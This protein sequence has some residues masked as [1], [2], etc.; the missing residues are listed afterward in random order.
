[1]V[2]CRKGRCFGDGVLSFRDGLE[3]EIP[4]GLLGWWESRSDTRKMSNASL[5]KGFL[6]CYRL[7]IN[8][9]YQS[10]QNITIDYQLGLIQKV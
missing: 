10:S 5:M 9:N 7:Q 8:F 2:T 1:M 4:V 6:A 3:N